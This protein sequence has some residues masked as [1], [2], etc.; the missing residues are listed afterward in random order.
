MWVR[1][2]ASPVVSST[3]ILTPKDDRGI[4]ILDELERETPAP[5]RVNT[6]TGARSY[7]RNADFAPPSFR[8]ILDRIDADWREHLEAHLT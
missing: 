2:L 3:L 5:F 4:A 8:E 6:R 7:W 1:W